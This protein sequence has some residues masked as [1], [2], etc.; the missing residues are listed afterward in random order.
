MP[1]RG[2]V[3]GVFLGYLL[4]LAAPASLVWGLAE[5]PPG[6]PAGLPP[7]V[8]M[9]RDTADL[10]LVMTSGNTNNTNF[11]FSNV[12]VF[13]RQATEMEFRARGLRV[14]TTNRTVT[15][16]FTD[17]ESPKLNIREIKTTTTENID[18]RLRLQRTVHKRLAWFAASSWE[19][20]RPAGLASR[21]T[22]GGGLAYTFFAQPAQFLRVEAGMDGTREVPETGDER[23]YAGF[24]AAARHERDLTRTS[25]LM[26]GIELL[27]NLKEGEDY[28]ANAEVSLAS[29]INNWL[30]LKVSCSVKYDHQPQNQLFR[31]PQTGPDLVFTFES[32]D[33]VFSTA[34]V[35]KF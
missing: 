28:R 16:D 25:R 35:M 6:P 12:L 4:G 15:P 19:R 14:R 26:A 22:L 17:P 7:P 29:T 34:L 9:W 32:T 21:S 27:Q 24:R 8:R 18:L 11:S 1:S 31:N 10:G 20:N 13:T 5:T 2:W 33:T 3:R 30:A 23:T